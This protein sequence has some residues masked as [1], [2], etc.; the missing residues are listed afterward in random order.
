MAYNGHQPNKLA[1][2]AGFGIG[3]TWIL[4]AL[5]TLVRAFGGLRDDRYDYG[6]AWTTVGVLLLAAGIAALIGT[7]WHQLRPPTDVH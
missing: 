3:L 5:Y 4:T 1:V 2:L 6:V 7:W